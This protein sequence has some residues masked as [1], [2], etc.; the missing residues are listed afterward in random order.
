[1]SLGSVCHKVVYV[2][3]LVI[4]IPY[5]YETGSANLSEKH[6]LKVRFEVLTELMMSLVYWK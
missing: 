5:G 4:A 3:K 1:M 6:V 2:T